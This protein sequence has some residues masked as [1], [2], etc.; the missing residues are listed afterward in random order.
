M[1]KFV[2]TLLI[3]LIPRVG[4]AYTCDDCNSNPTSKEFRTII[5]YYSELND[6]VSSLRRMPFDH[7]NYVVQGLTKHIGDLYLSYYYKNVG[8]NNPKKE[9]S[10]VV[11]YSYDDK[12]IKNV[13][14]LFKDGVGYTDHVGGV[15]V[16]KDQFVVTAGKYFYF[17]KKDGAPVI[18]DQGGYK[19]LRANYVK[20]IKPSMGANS[21]NSNFSFASLS[22]DH[23][24][25]SILWTGAFKENSDASD[26]L[27][28]EVSGNTF[29][30][31]PKYIFNVPSQVHKLQGVALV[32][33][34]AG[35]YKFL[36]A[37]SY[38]D[39][40]SYVYRLIYDMSGFNSTFKSRA[41]V[42]TGPAGM[43]NIHSTQEGIWSV[44]ESGAKY[45]QERKNDWNDYFPFIFRLKKEK[46]L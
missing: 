41:T 31:V 39:N 4:P 21:K 42:F 17:F 22:A 32:S 7:S 44:S 2:F 40:P 45:F 36:V 20:S 25:K 16:L 1:K 29:A 23:R 35:Q 34:T 27:G 19:T 9:S 10:V 13:W 43:E 15:V 11:Q 5:R 8:G 38:G 26:L 28:Y 3:L 24:G 46:L 30:T 33:A 12:K 37:R 14:K 6:K 18:E